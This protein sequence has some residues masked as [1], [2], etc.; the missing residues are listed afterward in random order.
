VC[1]SLMVLH[2][3]K[4]P[5]EN[6]VVDGFLFI[7]LSGVRKRTSMSVQNPP[8]GDGFIFCVLNALKDLVG[9]GSKRAGH[10]SERLT[11]TYLQFCL[12]T[13]FFKTVAL[14]AQ[15]VLYHT[16]CLSF[17]YF[18]HTGLLPRGLRCTSMLVL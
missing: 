8:M 4:T 17:F 18:L 13:Y 11:R 3:T 5:E 14:H 2:S 1:K 10:K 12:V 9:E 16:P 7:V 6:H 15:Y